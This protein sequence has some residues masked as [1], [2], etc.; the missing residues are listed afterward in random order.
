MLLEDLIKS[1]GGDKSA[2]SERSRLSYHIGDLKEEG[3]IDS[4]KEGR[5]LKVS[6]TFAGR[7]YAASLVDR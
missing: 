4:V 1:T 7:L 5:N 3:L 2:V 6:L